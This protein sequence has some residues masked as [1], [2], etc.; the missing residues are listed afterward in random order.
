VRFKASPTSEGLKQSPSRRDDGSTFIE[1]LV[2]IVLLGTV[3][4]A[5][6]AAVRVTIIATTTEREHSRAA[7]WLQSA[8]KAIDSAPFGNCSL[9]LGV[10]Q[11]SF[12][13]LQEY[14]AAVQAVPV[15]VGWS[16]N[17]ISVQRATDIDVWDGDSWEPYSTTSA[18]FDDTGL[19]LQRIRLTVENPDGQIIETLEVVKRG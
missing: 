8:E 13:A 6:L 17:Q 7:Q 5:V 16:A 12:N 15:P 18:C 9:V 4:V 1:L 10:P 2:A 11:S 3:V 19:R 14:N